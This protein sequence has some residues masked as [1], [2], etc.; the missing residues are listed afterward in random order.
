MANQN[1]RIFTSILCVA[2]LLFTLLCITSCD[3]STI[4]DY[5]GFSKAEEVY[6]VTFDSDGGTVID[7]VKV[8]RGDKVDEPC[9][10]TKEG[11]KFLGWYVGDEEWLF[12]GFSVTEDITLIAKWERIPDI[13]DGSPNSSLVNPDNW[14]NPD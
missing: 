8:K 12:I 1:K 14:T 13:D 7:P 3:I 11:Y 2:L 5:L 6:T 4:K 10:P 9:S